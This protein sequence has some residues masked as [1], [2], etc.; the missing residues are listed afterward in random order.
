MLLKIFSS[1]S[2]YIYS[3]GTDKHGRSQIYVN[4]Y[5]GSE[6]ELCGAKLEQK[7]RTF[8]ID[9]YGRRVG[10]S[11]RIPEY[12]RD[13]R[14]ILNGRS[15]PFIMK[16]QGYATVERVWYED[17]RLKVSF[18]EPIRIMA[19]NPKVRADRGLVCVTRGHTVYCA[20]GIDNGGEVDLELAAE[21]ELRCEGEY[22]VGKRSDDGKL[23]LI[24]FAKRCNRGST[25]NSDRRMAVW[26]R[27]AG[28]PDGDTIARLA[29]DKLYFE[30]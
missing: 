15:V 18:D 3:Y 13:F 19:A 27:Q 11:F 17:D 14:L 12:A 10:V 6:T 7:D 1:L 25:D 9:S 29:G 26:L 16:H 24:P 4:T 30:I 2:S 23:T 28:L 5:I 22:I 20:E 8:R 21:P